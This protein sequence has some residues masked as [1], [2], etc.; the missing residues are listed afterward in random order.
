MTFPYI[1]W[2]DSGSRPDAQTF[3]LSMKHRS[4]ALVCALVS[5]AA[6]TLAADCKFATVAS[7]STCFSIAQAAGITTDQLLS[8]NPGLD[9]SVL[10]LGQ[11]LC[12]SSGTLPGQP[13]QNPDGSCATYTTVPNDS[14]SAIGVKLSITVANIETWNANTFRWKGTSA[15]LSPAQYCVT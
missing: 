13:Q 15:P 3:L 11:K 9:C 2:H 1:N 8:F 5:Y 12:I 4:G 6:R 7:G 10:A 14:C